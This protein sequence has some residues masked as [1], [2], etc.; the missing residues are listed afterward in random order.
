M[1]LSLA[2]VEGD[3]VVRHDPREPLRHVTHLEDERGVGHGAGFYGVDWPGVARA[4][5][6]D[7]RRAGTRPALRQWV[8]YVVR[9]FAGGLIF[10]S[11]ISLET[12]VSLAISFARF[13]ALTLTL[14]KP[15]PPFLTV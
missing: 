8:C 2:Q 7:V 6:P 1:H 4:L 9:Y 10:P 3:V 15:R 14:P 5:P 13:G 12:A 11:A